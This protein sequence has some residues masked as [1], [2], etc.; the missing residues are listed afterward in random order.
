LIDLIKYGWKYL[1]K[2]H[3]GKI[4]SQ[5]KQTDPIISKEI[6][7]IAKKIIPND[8]ELSIYAEGEEE[9]SSSIEIN[10]DNE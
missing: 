10:D 8:S 3:N 9:L 5:I 7:T 1:K 6:S 2:T 4:H